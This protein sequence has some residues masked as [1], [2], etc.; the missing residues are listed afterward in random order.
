[1][2]ILIGLVGYVISLIRSE[3]LHMTIYNKGK[4]Q[5]PPEIP[6]KKPEMMIREPRRQRQNGKR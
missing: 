2:E 1:M 4:S 5:R 3:L 6:P